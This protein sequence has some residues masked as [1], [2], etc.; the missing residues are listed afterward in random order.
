METDFTTTTAIP[1]FL[2]SNMTSPRPPPSQTSSH[3]HPRLPPKQHDVLDDHPR[4]VRGCTRPSSE[5]WTPSSRAWAR[6][7]SAP[8]KSLIGSA[9]SRIL[10]D[11]LPHMKDLINDPNSLPPKPKN[12]AKGLNSLQKATYGARQTSF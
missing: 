8:D 2:P 3:R 10:F 9:L 6:I 1:N 7:W 4:R 5:L 11:K 12:M